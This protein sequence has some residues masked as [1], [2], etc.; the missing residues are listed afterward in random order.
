MSAHIAAN[1]KGK[2]SFMEGQH[3]ARLGVVTTR[4]L[5]LRALGSNRE[6]SLTHELR[7]ALQWSV[8]GVPRC[9][10]HAYGAVEGEGSGTCT[11]AFFPSK[12]PEHFSSHVPDVL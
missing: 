4:A 10:L 3:H 11:K 5:G 8:A 1:F 12:R 6:M 7:A 9:H 2:L